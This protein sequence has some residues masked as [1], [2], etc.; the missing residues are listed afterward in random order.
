MDRSSSADMRGKL[1]LELGRLANVLGFF[2]RVPLPAF[3]FDER[4]KPDRLD[5][6]AIWFPVAGLLIG[7]FPATIYFFAANLLP[8]T[9]AAGLAVATGMLV[10][11]ALHEDGLSDCADGLGGTRDKQRALEIMRDSRIGTYGAAALVFSLGLRWAALATLSPAA[12]VAALLISHAAARGSITTALSFS[13]YARP[14]GTASVVERGIAKDQWAMNVAISLLLSF[15]LGG[16]WG[17]LATICGLSV[18]ALFLAFFARRIGGYTGDALGGMEQLSE[19]TILAVL[20]CGWAPG[21]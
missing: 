8:A 6:A 12:G 18:A 16:W 11:G 21:R 9:V 5:D 1:R 19:I 10:S 13:Y 2:S 3:L 14:H 7:I 17:G 4:A 15:L 20:S